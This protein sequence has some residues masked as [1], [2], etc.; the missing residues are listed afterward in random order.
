M[1]PNPPAYAGTTSAGNPPRQAL[2]LRPR[3]H[4][5]LAQARN[6]RSERPAFHRMEPAGAERHGRAGR[7]T[8]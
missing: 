3:L 6:T 2:T 5:H 7:E 1:H 8:E 4:R